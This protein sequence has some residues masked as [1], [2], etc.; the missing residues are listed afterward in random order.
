MA[1]K[2]CT[3]QSAIEKLFHRPQRIHR[4]MQ[5]LSIGI[6]HADK[7]QT[8]FSIGKPPIGHGFLDAHRISFEIEP[9]MKVKQ[10]VMQ[11]SCFAPFT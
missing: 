7:R 2:K 3:V 1:T 6:T 9:V 8:D 4:L 10:F 5:P 11:V